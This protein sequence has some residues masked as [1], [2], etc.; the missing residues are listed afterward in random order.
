MANEM[1]GSEQTF[2]PGHFVCGGIRM[3]VF[4]TPALS[5]PSTGVPPFYPLRV[6]GVHTPWRGQGMY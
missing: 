5:A 3:M 4:P 6:Q 1:T 2:G